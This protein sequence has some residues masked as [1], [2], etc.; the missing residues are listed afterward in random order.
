MAFWLYMI[1]VILSLPKTMVFVALGNPNSEN[2]KGNKYAKVV[3]IG[4]LVVITSSYSFP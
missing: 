1:T 2:S 3:A 4:V